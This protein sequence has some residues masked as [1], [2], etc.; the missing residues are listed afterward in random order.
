MQLKGSLGQWR[1]RLQRALMAG[2]LLGIPCL[3][4]M[5]FGPG[6]MPVLGT[7]AFAGG[8]MPLDRPLAPGD[9]SLAQLAYSTN[10]SEADVL[11]DWEN[12]AKKTPKPKTKVGKQA[13]AAVNSADAKINK[14]LN[15]LG[16]AESS[17]NPKAIANLEAELKA[18]EVKETAELKAL[19]KGIKLAP[20][21]AALLKSLAAQVKAS[22]ANLAVV[23]KELA[24]LAKQFAAFQTASAAN[25]AAILAQLKAL[26]NQIAKVAATVAKNTGGS[27]SGANKGGTGSL[28]G[29]GSAGKGAGNGNQ[30]KNTSNSG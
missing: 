8:V 27:T 29:G 24:T 13:L 7:D 23:V 16:K 19:A 17:G 3:A 25:Q 2:A 21:D 9:Y 1:Q 12:T 15:Q 10:D 5:G 26:A 28:G 14:L 22:Q 6:L 18:A 4:V 20:A 11:A 30:G